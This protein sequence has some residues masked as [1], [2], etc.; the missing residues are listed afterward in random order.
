M[1]NT[2]FLKLLNLPVALRTRLCPAI[3][4][5]KLRCN[6]VQLGSN[7]VIFNRFY[8]IG[9]SYCSVLLGRFL[10]QSEI[11]KRYVYGEA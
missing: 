11:I 2:I 4:R 3:N 9:G 7:C 10:R 1:R 5:L 6:G 8:I